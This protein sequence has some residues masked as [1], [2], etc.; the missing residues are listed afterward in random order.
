MAGRGPSRARLAVLGIAVAACVAMAPGKAAAA[1]TVNVAPIADCYVTESVT[2]NQCSLAELRVGQVQVKR[3]VCSDACGWV[4]TWHRAH[5]LLHFDVNSA[6][7]AGAEIV[8]AQL[9]LRLES[10]GI[11]G[12]VDVAPVLPP[13]TSAARWTERDAGAPW[14]TPGGD[15]D[16]VLS[17]ATPR[18]PGTRY[19]WDV[20]SIARRW[21]DGTYGN[22]GLILTGRDEIDLAKTASFDSVEHPNASSRPVL[23]VTYQDDSEAPDVY[24]EGVPYDDRSSPMSRDLYRLAITAEDAASGIADVRVLLDGAIAF[25]RSQGCPQGG[26]DLET[27]DAQIDARGLTGVHRIDVVATDVAGHSK[28]VTWTDDFEGDPTA[29]PWEGDDPLPARSAFATS[30]AADTE[31]LAA[32]GDAATPLKIVRGSWTTATGVRAEQSTDY[33][34]GS[35]RVTRCGADGKLVLSQLVTTLQPRGSAAGPY[36]IE[37]VRPTAS[38]EVEGSVALLPSPDDPAFVAWWRS[39]GAAEAAARAIPP[40]TTGTT[41]RPAA[42]EA[43]LADPTPCSYTDFKR[44]GPR[45]Q[46]NT[47]SMLYSFNPGTLPP[48]QPGTNLPYSSE[49]FQARLLSAARNW[50]FGRNRCGFYQDGGVDIEPFDGDSATTSHRAGVRDDLNVIDLGGDMTVNGRCMD[51]PIACAVWWAHDINGPLPGEGTIS[52]VD[53]R[54]DVFRRWWTG[55]RSVPVSAKDGCTS[56][57]QDRCGMFD[58]WSV[59]THEMGHMIGIDHVSEDRNAPAWV[60]AQVMYFSIDPKETKRYLAGS[61]Y[62]AMC[63]MYPCY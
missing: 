41:V 17:S 54:F 59:A 30:C 11:N 57:N 38:G 4:T 10:G 19:A 18:T 5:T 44:A 52:E 63:R 16:D 32:R 37:E 33:Y 51:G 28:T 34:S 62:T 40:T 56:S 22:S 2:Q 24:V 61:D 48:E 13:W 47:Y 25:Q 50:R 1:T 14:A 6:V 3:W 21:R 26:C 42:T 31:A 49:R 27:D 39:G 15:A 12:L 55:I 35:Y 60:K 45:L 29:V 53:I 23:A 36:V 58:L 9:S 20:T 43:A 46:A 8:S 7:P